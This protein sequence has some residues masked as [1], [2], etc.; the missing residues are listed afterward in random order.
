[1]TALSASRLWQAS[2]WLLLILSV[3]S[4][5]FGW[6]HSLGNQLVQALPYVLAAVLVVIATM[7][8]RSRLVLPVLLLVG[9]YWAIQTYFQQEM[10]D[11]AYWQL[12]SLHLVLLGGMMLCAL[13]PEKGATHPFTLIS[14]AALAL[15]FYG[16]QQ[17]ELGARF[18]TIL[19]AH[20]AWAALAWSEERYWLSKALPL[21][22]AAALLVLLAGRWWYKDIASKA[23]VMA[24]VASFYV[25]WVFN[26]HLASSVIYTGLMLALL[27]LFFQNNYQVTY[28]DALTGI[29]GRRSLEDYLPTLSRHY[30]I[31]MLDV[32]HFKKFNDTHGHDV[33]DQVLKMVASQ[34]N[35]VQGGGRA[36]RYGGEEFTV[37]FNRKQAQDCYVFLEAVR[38]SIAQYE[39]VLR[40]NDRADDAKEGKMQRGRKQAPKEQSLSVTISIGVANSDAGLSVEEV[41]KK[42]DEALYAAKQNGRNQ[43]VKAGELPQ[44]KL[45]TRKKAA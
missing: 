21:I 4:L 36:F 17:G 33:G 44:P 5:E 31:A 35:K 11:Q 27:L 23:L 28:M 34:V 13:L 19:E 12:Q 6:H 2:P 32:D 39:M 26:Q 42:A 10:S 38:E 20:M 37:V 18:S 22:S 29:P 14:A 9:T 43:T 3:C 15:G 41:I 30:A 16:W 24:C 45:R 1:M 40:S 25:M 7:F 8:N